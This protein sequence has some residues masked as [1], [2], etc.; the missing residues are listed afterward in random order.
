MGQATPKAVLNLQPG[1]L[2]A[3]RSTR[4]SCDSEYRQQESRHGLPMPKWFILRKNLPVLRRVTQIVNE[5]NG[6]CRYEE[7][8]HHSR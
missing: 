2:V 8:L 7:P 3:R 4:N 5:K 1:E 6:R